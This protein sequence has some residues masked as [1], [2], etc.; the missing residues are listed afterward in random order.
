MSLPVRVP[1]RAEELHESTHCGLSG[2]T[3]RMTFF[4]I[5][6]PPSAQRGVS[7]HE[8][9]VVFPTS[10]LVAAALSHQIPF[11]TH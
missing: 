10:C 4:R 2:L 9:V 1:A 8:A 3:R 7:L 6:S 11:S 5:S